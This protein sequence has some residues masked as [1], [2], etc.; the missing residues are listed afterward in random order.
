VWV[1]ETVHDLYGYRTGQVVELPLAGRTWRFTVAGVWRDYARQNG[2]I[3]MDR[4]LY[5]RIT[6]D[7]LANDAAIWLAPGHTIPEVASELRSLLPD[8]PEAEIADTR[9]IRMLSLSIFDRTFAV[10]YGLEAVAVLI[11]L[12]GISVSVGSQV[13]A[14]RGE[15]GMLRHIG[16]TRGQVAAMLGAEGALTSTLGVALGFGFGWVISVILVHVI[17]RQS[18]HWSM[19]MHFPWGGL[20]AL[21]CMLIASAALTAAWS[22]RRAMGDDV[23]RA[24]REDW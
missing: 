8:A 17:N 19:D 22:G 23:V 11:G 18:F 24:V 16:M 15:F 9:S 10:T 14:R 7:Q 6:G 5:A 4:D 21:G 1:S 12:F 3:Y 2:A 20:A 13:L